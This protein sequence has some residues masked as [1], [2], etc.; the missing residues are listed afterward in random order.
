MD[1]KRCQQNVLK[2]NVKKND[3]PIELNIMSFGITCKIYNSFAL[4]FAPNLLL[5]WYL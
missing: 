4:P 3:R 1:A 5:A 2:K